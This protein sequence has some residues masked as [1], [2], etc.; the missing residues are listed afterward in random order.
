MM[1]AGW[2]FL[3]APLVVLGTAGSVGSEESR[4]G[5]TRPGPGTLP[6]GHTWRQGTT[7]F[8]RMARLKQRV[9]AASVKRLCC[10]TL[11]PKSRP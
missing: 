9:Q 11:A 2:H 4:P 1:G 10:R 5:C 6:T 7:T 3:R 8:L